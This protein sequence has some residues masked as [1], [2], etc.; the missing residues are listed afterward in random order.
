MSSVSA[1]INNWDNMENREKQ[2]DPEVDHNHQ[3]A[4]G[5][6]SALL[7]SVALV[8]SSIK[9][10]L[11]RSEILTRRVG[12]KRN[13]SLVRRFQLV[14][15][16]WGLVVYII[17]V[18]GFWFVS[19]HFIQNTFQQQAVHWLSR[20][21]ELS[22]PLY[23]SQKAD[24]FSGIQRYIK[25]FPEIFYVKFYDAN[26]LQV[27]AEYSDKTVTDINRPQFDKAVFRHFTDQQLKDGRSISQK[28]GDDNN[29]LRM[30]APVSII[31]M[32]ADDM[33]EFDLEAPS[34][35]RVS[36][37]GYIDMGLNFSLHQAK[38]AENILQG[39]ILISIVFLFAAII[40]RQLT[41][42]ALKPLLDL[43]EPLD[44]LARGETDVW[45]GKGDGD[46]EIVAISN[47]LNTT[48]NAIRGRDEELRRLADYDPLT[49][50]VNKRSFNKLLE[51]ERRRVIDNRDCSALFFIDLDQ[52]KY[53]ND[54]LG[55]ASGDRLLIQI[56]ELLT[57]RMRTDDVVARIGGD[58]FAVLAKSVDK[59]GAIEIANSIVKSMYDFLFTE[60]G[61]SFNIYCSV[62]AG[63]IENNHYSAE[64][65]FSNV[66]MACYSAKSQGRNR[67]IFFEQGIL[68]DNKVDI[69]W[70]HRIAA[71]LA[72]DSF[73]LHYQPIMAMSN[74]CCPSYEVLLRMHDDEDE[75]VPPNMFI[76][77]AERFGLATEIDYWVIKK[78]MQVLDALNKAGRKSRFF[79]NLSGQLLIDP[80]FVD[81]VVSIFELVDID[82]SQVV[83]ELT[84][85]AAVGNVHS[86][87]KKME[88]LKKFG[89]EFAVD[90]FG[91]G[92]SSFSYLKHMPVEYVKIE[93]EFVER[94]MED[95][96]DRALVK[97]M[98]DIARACGKKT[99]AE[100]VPDQKTLD[101]LKSYGIDFAQG[102]FI[103]EPEPEPVQPDI[104]KPLPNN[105]SKFK[106]RR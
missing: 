5:M 45:V 6:I 8:F 64:E 75:L 17:A 10:R 41:K 99:V 84:E 54:T 49:G 105:V 104:D 30:M 83:F 74:S 85:R 31:S 62:G 78:S 25:N 94:M 102:F 39:S 88:K 7:T 23:V 13:G 1:G 98:I 40:G 87:S 3:P 11:R 86:A 12:V 67:F 97:S 81:R 14:L 20:L 36:V 52:F 71:A 82:A 69:G 65:I 16:S 61:K 37:I 47:A 34:I 72:N 55:H 92:F 38:L 100:Y 22:T 68:G 51:D 27:L 77:V 90:D 95:D 42:R 21:D 53:V 63:L 26:G 93:G 44:Q 15:V 32:Q 70:S 103:A 59:P 58:E 89:F 73:V 80:E 91:S 60:Q 19:S 79:V 48:I 9:S 43:K 35:E 56:A 28:L 57:T 24:E 96:V 33:L 101:V 46:E 76:P 50:L 4:A 29:W 106:S 66:D 18:F 2:A